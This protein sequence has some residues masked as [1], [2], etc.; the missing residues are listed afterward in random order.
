MKTYSASSLALA[1][2][3]SSYIFAKQVVMELL[4]VNMELD[5]TAHASLCP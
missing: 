3:Q 5:S 4:L 2:L 1:G